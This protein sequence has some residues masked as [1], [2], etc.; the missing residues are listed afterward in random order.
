MKAGFI[1]KKIQAVEPKQMSF[2]RVTDFSFSKP[3]DRSYSQRT[4]IM[5]E[6]LNKAG[7]EDEGHM[8][9]DFIIL[10]RSKSENPAK[11]D[12]FLRDIKT[13]WP[14]LKTLRSPQ[15]IDRGTPGSGKQIKFP[16]IR[17]PKSFPLEFLNIEENHSIFRSKPE[18][19]VSYSEFIRKSMYSTHH[20]ILIRCPKK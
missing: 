7:A 15:N 18:T 8:S 2:K 3:N 11:I 6:S 19:G 12:G 10:R 20:Q 17:A 13:N 14:T 9:G 1:K 5:R 4:S 16:K